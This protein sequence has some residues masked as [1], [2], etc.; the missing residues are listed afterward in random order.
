MD[1]AGF[2]S[3]DMRITRG[4]ANNPKATAETITPDGWL[5]TGDVVTVDKDGFISITDR[6]KELIKYK[7]WRLPSVLLII[8]LI[9]LFRVS[10]VC[11]T[12]I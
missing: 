11:S 5:R 7:V 4:Y 1:P 10:K 12:A 6:I 8:P 2:V 3:A 9:L